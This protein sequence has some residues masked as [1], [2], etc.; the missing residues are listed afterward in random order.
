LL[1]F[2]YQTDLWATHELIKEYG[3]HL[4]D[5]LDYNKFNIKTVDLT[6]IKKF[7][8]KTLDDADLSFVEFGRQNPDVII[9]S[10]DGDALNLC[11]MFQLRSF[12]LSEFLLYLA[13]NEFLK[14]K[15]AYSPIKYLREWKNIKEKKFDRLK[16]EL[17]ALR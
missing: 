6:A 3:Y 12:Q 10:D 1:P 15:N 11:N 9:I 16:T 17:N 4:G 5:Y 14:K 7:V 13:K 2:I 8:E